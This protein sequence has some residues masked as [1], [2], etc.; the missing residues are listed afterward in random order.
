M[1]EQTINVNIGKRLKYCRNM[2]GLS[3]QQVGNFIGVSF[4]QVQKYERGTNTISALKL[5]ELAK[6]LEV[7]VSYFLEGYEEVL[8]QS[9]RSETDSVIPDEGSAALL[10][11]Y[12]RI[13]DIG[14]KT[15]LIALVK[16]MAENKAF[17]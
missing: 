14:L 8:N 1:N 6:Y 4:Q 15:K 12:N 2:R 13:T 9:T 17:L 10:R 5:Y 7:P 16:A 3:Q 11:H